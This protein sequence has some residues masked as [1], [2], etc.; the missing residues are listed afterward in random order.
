MKKLIAII[1]TGILLTGFSINTI[2]GGEEENNE[3]KATMTTSLKGTVV[4]QSTG[5]VLTGV[6]V[7]V[8]G[9]EK[10]A[11]T[12]FEGNFKFAELRPG[13]YELVASYISYKDQIFQDVKL[14]LSESNQ[15]TLK[16]ESLEK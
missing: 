15:V 12:D 10:E 6:R 14:E 9:S 1:I 2:A 4:D 8:K 3:S 5:E 7:E 16:L 13:N 11:Y